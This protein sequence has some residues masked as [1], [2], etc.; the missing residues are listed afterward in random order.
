MI[1]FTHHFETILVNE[2]AKMYGNLAKYLVDEIL[3]RYDITQP[4][5]LI[6]HID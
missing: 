1:T 2:A 5:T 6:P 3:S 4:Y